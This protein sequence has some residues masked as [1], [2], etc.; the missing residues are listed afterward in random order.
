VIS[1]GMN[2]SSRFS[3][4]GPR[5][6]YPQDI[7]VLEGTWSFPDVNIFLGLKD[8]LLSG[9]TQVRVD[10]PSSSIG[11]LF[12][13]PATTRQVTRKTSFTGKVE[14]RVCKFKLE[15]ETLSDDSFAT[16]SQMLGGGKPSREGY[17]V[18]SADGSSAEVCELKNGKPSE[19]YSINKSMRQQVGQ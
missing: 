11:A 13:T 3:L 1:T 12:G 19:L 14:G 8:G 6:A 16:L 5:V 10:L 17:L 9:Q 15:T 7:P 4:R 18:F 2:D